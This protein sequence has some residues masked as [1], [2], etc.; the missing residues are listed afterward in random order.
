VFEDMEN[1]NLFVVQSSRMSYAILFMDIA[2]L[3]LVCFFSVCA[4]QGKS[5]F[6]SSDDNYVKADALPIRDE[7]K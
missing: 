1:S 2:I 4:Y 3:V 6:K 7:I 5:V